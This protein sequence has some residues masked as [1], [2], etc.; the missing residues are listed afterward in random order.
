[1]IGLDGGDF[2]HLFMGWN[3]GGACMYNIGTKGFLFGDT[4]EYSSFSR[5]KHLLVE[6]RFP[7]WVSILLL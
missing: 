6:R 2:N 4:A 5:K 1:V 3:N 7:L